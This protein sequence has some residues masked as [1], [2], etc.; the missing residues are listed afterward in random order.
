MNHTSFQAQMKVSRINFAFLA[1]HLCA[2]ETIAGIIE[3]A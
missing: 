2:S 1:D 3:L